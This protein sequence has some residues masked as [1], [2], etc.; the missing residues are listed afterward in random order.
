MY[1]P[2]VI[3]KLMLICSQYNGIPTYYMKDRLPKFIYEI[4]HLY[5]IL[6]QIFQI[7]LVFQR[8]S[9]NYF[10][11]KFSYSYVTIYKNEIFT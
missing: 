7:K 11:Y 8:N 2:V 6:N 3:V 9:V 4:D 1:I 10:S 5:E